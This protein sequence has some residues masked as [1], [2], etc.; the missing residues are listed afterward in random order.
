[1]RVAMIGTTPG[2][3]RIERALGSG[4]MGDVYLAEDLVL[5][6]RERWSHQRGAQLGGGASALT[7]C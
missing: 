1:M 4:G 7:S 2:H 6:R 3:Y 5:H